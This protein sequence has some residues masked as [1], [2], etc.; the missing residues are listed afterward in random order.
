MGNKRS[1]LIPTVHGL[2]VVK[3]CTFVERNDFLRGNFHAA[4]VL[5]KG[6]FKEV[7]V[8]SDLGMDAEYVSN[9]LSD[10]MAEGISFDEDFLQSKTINDG[11]VYLC[12]LDSFDCH[13]TVKNT[14]NGSHSALC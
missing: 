9:H 3:F 10:I 12:K 1:S 2:L 7:S 8:V 13:G 11:R 5:F 4:K 6:I 14:A